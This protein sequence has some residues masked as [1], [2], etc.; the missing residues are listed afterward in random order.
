MIGPDYCLFLTGRTLAWADL[1]NLA[2]MCQAAQAGTRRKMMSHDAHGRLADLNQNYIRAVRESDVAWFDAH[3]SADF[4]N[5]NPDGTLVGRADFL[6]QI[7]KPSA[8]KNIQ[9]EDVRIRIINDTA[10]IHA[11]TTYIRPDGQPGAGRY[12]DIWM[13]QAGAGDWRCVA[14]HVT[15]A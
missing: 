6:T 1:I 4:L 11:R 13:K 9:C 2:E 8:A 3:L 14:A 12:T 7:A 10:L 15:R 5:S